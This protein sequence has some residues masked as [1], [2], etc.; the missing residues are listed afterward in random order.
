[1]LFRE[2]KTCGEVKPHSEFHKNKKYK[3][4]IRP[5][6]KVCRREYE[7]K[8]H[9]KHKHKRPYRYEEDKN[10]KLQRTYGIS[11]Q[12][13]L[14]MLEAQ[15]GC[16]AICGTDDPKPRKAFCVDHCHKTGKVRS[17]L[18]GKC[19]TGIGLLQEDIGIMLRAIEYISSHR[20]DTDL[21]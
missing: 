13:Y 21:G 12:E 19:N 18:C 8:S 7:N 10:I 15:S 14:Y 2:C 6:C 9:H 4:N 20:N 1:M 5:H 3:D 16:C 11:Y 17:L